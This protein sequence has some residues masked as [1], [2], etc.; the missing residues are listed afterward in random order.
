MPFVKLDCGILKSTIWFHR[1]QRDVFLTALLMAEPRE[2][3]AP[4]PQLE[5]DTLNKTGLIVPPG[6][7]GFVEAS[8]KGIAHQAQ[9]PPEA[10]M[11]ALRALGEPDVES[12]SQDFE[13]RRLVRVDGGYIV[14]NYM[15]YR[16]RDYTAA[17]RQSR[18]RK[19]KDAGCNAVTV[20]PSR[21]N[22]TQA[23][24]EAEVEAE[25][26]ATLAVPPAPV[27]TLTKP[28]A[29]KPRIDVAWPGRPPV[30][31]AL[32]AEFT[33][34]LGG[35]PYE[36]DERLRKWY[37][38]AAAPYEGQPI[39]DDDWKFWRLRFRE[40]QGTTARP[41]QAGAIAATDDEI[42]ADIEAQKAL[43]VRR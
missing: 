26:L 21:R 7:Y 1:D 25:P 24:V 18:W 17:E 3:T 27:K 2:L 20:T 39:G 34:K 13:G 35:D 22:I 11:A 33:D 30:P 9:V 40:W 10:G 19:R 38:V 41:V 4:A 14:L 16:E 42:W 12:R 32:H 31:S 5:V 36:A 23:E 29:Y 6:W 8:G 37:P 15:R 28:L 43:R